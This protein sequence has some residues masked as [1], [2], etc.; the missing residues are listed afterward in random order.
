MRRALAR[1]LAGAGIVLGLA[2]SVHAGPIRTTTPVDLDFY[3][4]SML[5]NA[6]NA[7]S[8]TLLVVTRFY[9]LIGDLVY[10][11]PA[12][13]LAPGEGIT[14]LAPSGKFVTYCQFVVKSGIATDLR[15]G[16]VISK[17]GRYLAT[18]EAR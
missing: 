2:G 6:A 3:G 17:S 9:D 16:A 18:S 5:C 13:A 7:G 12:L 14:H 15:A 1:A 11:T 8:G 10:A 4:Y